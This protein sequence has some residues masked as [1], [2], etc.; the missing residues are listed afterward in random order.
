[1]CD[2]HAIL[3]PLLLAVYWGPAPHGEHKG[4]HYWP[5]VLATR[6]RCALSIPI[7]RQHT[8]TRVRIATEAARCDSKGRTA[9]CV[10]RAQERWDQV[11][12]RL[13]RDVL[14][15][16]GR[17]LVLVEG[18]GYCQSKSDEGCEW[19]SAVGQD[20]KTTSWWGENLQ[21]A[22]QRPST[23]TL[24]QLCTRTAQRPSTRTLSQLCTR[25]LWACGHAVALILP[26]PEHYR[27]PT[28]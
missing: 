10:R 4:A 11:A 23:R 17:W 9:L 24:S 8:H 20:V 12:E 3:T 28:L 22:A 5:Q 7:H 21:A 19:P 14:R 16:C 6:E 13:G 1:M 27:T 26:S 15:A 25:T 2:L 18:V